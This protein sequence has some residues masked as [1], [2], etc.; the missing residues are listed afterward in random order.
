MVSSAFMLSPSVRCSGSMGN[1]R[2]VILITVAVYEVILIR[3]SDDVV[4]LG[5]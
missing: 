5:H 2:I 3:T 1:R 4:S